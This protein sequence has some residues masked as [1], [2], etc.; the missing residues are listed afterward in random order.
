MRRGRREGERGGREEREGRRVEGEKR[1]ERERRE[2]GKKDGGREEGGK[3]N[4]EGCLVVCIHLLACFFLPSESLIMYM[5]DFI[6]HTKSSHAYYCSQLKELWF[7]H[8]TYMI[9]HC[10]YTSQ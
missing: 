3:G 5:G 2:G 1:G 9:V 4:R 8:I 7:I 6:F 10:T